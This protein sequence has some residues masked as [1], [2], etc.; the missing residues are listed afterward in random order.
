MAGVSRRHPHS[1]TIPESLERPL[2]QSSTLLWVHV[3]VDML[4]GSQR[5]GLQEENAV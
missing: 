1:L 2:I 4:G 5:L 3:W